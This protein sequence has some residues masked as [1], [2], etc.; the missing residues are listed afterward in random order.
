MDITYDTRWV[1]SIG[2]DR[3]MGISSEVSGARQNRISEYYSGNSS[4]FN[5]NIINNYGVQVPS[6]VPGMQSFMVNLRLN[7]WLRIFV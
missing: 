2:L 1:L 5:T 3:L 4:S 7:I 6:H